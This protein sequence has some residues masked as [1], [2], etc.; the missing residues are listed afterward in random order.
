MPRS[1]E[2]HQH[3]PLRSD[4]LLSDSGSLIGLVEAVRALPYGRPSERTVEG[5]LR[6][7]R[8][9]CSTKHLFLARALAERYPETEPRIV[10]RVYWLDRTRA[11]RLFGAAVAAVVP[12]TGLVDVHRYL[13]ARIGRRRIPLDVTFPDVQRWDGL[14]PLPLPRM[15]A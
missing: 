15:S 12:E 8:G 1:D 7:R 14:S 4:P 5:M 6:E 3:H 10:H 2:T 11:L 13:T 9:T